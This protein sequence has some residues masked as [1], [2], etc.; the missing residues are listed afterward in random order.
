MNHSSDYT[1]LNVEFKFLN[2]L[3]E[4][5]RILL[6]EN[7]SNILSL[8]M[9]NKNDSTPILV[10]KVEIQFDNVLTPSEIEQIQIED[11][12]NNTESSQDGKTH[13][14]VATPSQTSTIIVACGDTLN[15]NFNSIQPVDSPLRNGLI[16]VLVTGKT[17]DQER[18]L[19]FTQAIHVTSATPPKKL[20][21]DLS[22]VFVNEMNPSHDG[23][24]AQFEYA[25]YVTGTP[26]KKGKPIKNKLLLRFSN[27]KKNESLVTQNALGDARFFLS[28]IDTE[29]ERQGDSGL[30]S[31]AAIKAIDMTP[32]LMDTFA[33][34]EI[35][36]NAQL[37]VPVWEVIPLQE[38]ILDGN[39]TLEVEIGNIVTHKMS[40]STNLY[41]SYKNVPGYVDGEFDP[42]PIVFDATEAYI[43]SFLINNHR[44][45]ST[46][47]HSIVHLTFTVHS[48]KDETWDIISDEGEWIDSFTT[49]AGETY[50]GRK[51]HYVAEQ[52][53]QK[54]VL[55]PSS[56]IT[57]DEV[58]LD[59]TWEPYDY[60]RTIVLES[61]GIGVSTLELDLIKGK[62]GALI[63]R[64]KE[65]ENAH[66]GLRI[67]PDYSVVFGGNSDAKSDEFY[68]RSMSETDYTLKTILSHEN[69]DTAQTTSFDLIPWNHSNH[70]CGFYLTKLY[71]A[72][73]NTLTLYSTNYLGLKPYQGPDWTECMTTQFHGAPDVT[74]VP[75]I[76]GF[77]KTSSTK[78]FEKIFVNT[79]KEIF[80]LD[81]SNHSISVTTTNQGDILK[82][83]GIVA[84]NI[85]IPSVVGD[86]SIYFFGRKY[87]DNSIYLIKQ[88]FEGNYEILLHL[89]TLPQ[90]LAIDY[91]GADNSESSPEDYALCWFDGEYTSGWN[92][93]TVF[94]LK[95]NSIMKTF[96]VNFD[97]LVESFSQNNQQITGFVIQKK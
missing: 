31:L 52:G 67:L 30:A 81:I 96:P 97:D 63:R 47:V 12:D 40:G 24:D 15:V 18:Q 90:Y 82:F 73:L 50:N 20:S 78:C 33:A 42:I 58:Y 8:E 46:E 34:C 57:R 56:K 48:L 35:K 11:W 80:C 60:Q 51:S 38:N 87:A 13:Y 2:N 44:T 84:S 64:N 72:G 55:Q 22:V 25:N 39:Q 5:G 94:S 1:P 75:G 93:F 37:D 53:T 36:S 91:N 21:E 26:I 79:F 43:G 17:G 77:P 86:A 32:H 41:V 65:N 83:P 85:V 76:E 92:A 71:G 59:V 62:T 6:V 54:I 95:T 89:E 7:Q 74:T 14:T 10:S 45:T 66:G 88:D 16:N 29:I 4:G 27:L 28:F 3:D 70:W 23:D 69:E 9:T 68:F 61:E 49:R 19:S